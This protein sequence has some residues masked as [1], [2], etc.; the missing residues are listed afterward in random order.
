M[1]DQ[2]NDENYRDPEDDVPEESSE[3]DHSS[4]AGSVRRRT[5]IS[6]STRSLKRDHKCDNATFAYITG[7]TMDNSFE[8]ATLARLV[9]ILSAA[10]NLDDQ[11]ILQEA[12]KQWDRVSNSIGAILD[13][14]AAHLDFDDDQHASLLIPN[15]DGNTPNFHFAANAA[16][17][18]WPHVIDVEIYDLVAT[19][20][21]RFRQRS[22]TRPAFLG[23]RSGN[24]IRLFRGQIRLG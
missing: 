13:D 10:G 21:F 2:D 6:T 24:K 1:S 3:D 4:D 20:P 22:Y 5:Y 23:P 9:V 8:T 17:Y 12:H 15:N 7:A 14:A 16:L 18:D 19:V 11:D